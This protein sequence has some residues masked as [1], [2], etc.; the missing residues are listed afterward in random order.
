MFDKLLDLFRGQVESAA[1]ESAEAGLNEASDSL[2]EHAERV[3]DEYR[4]AAL[5][6][7]QEA[8]DAMAEMLKPSKGTS[9]RRKRPHATKE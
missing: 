5:A 8:L 3:K 6:G 1:I 7:M 9:T 4:E 2:T